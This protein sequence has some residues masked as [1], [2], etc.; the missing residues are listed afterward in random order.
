M[1]LKTYLTLV[2][3]STLLVNL[4]LNQFWILL[5]TFI[6]L[7]SFIIGIYYHSFIHDNHLSISKIKTIN[8]KLTLMGVT[9][10]VGLLLPIPPSFSMLL[11]V[12][13]GICFG[14]I[15]MNHNYEKEISYEN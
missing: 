8:L 11:A 7:Q 14:L 13:F 3:N 15:I 6:L 10:F 4:Y 2:L 5:L 9:C 12:A 1:K